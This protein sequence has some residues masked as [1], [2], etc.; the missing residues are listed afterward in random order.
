VNGDVDYFSFTAPANARIWAYVDT[1]GV[2]AGTSVDSLLQLIATDGTTQLELDDSDGT[3]NGL[4][5]TVETESSS[6]IAGLLGPPAGGLIYARISE[7]GDNGTINPM[8][9]YVVT[10]TTSTP[11]VEGAGGNNSCATANQL[12]SG[13]PHVGVRTGEIPAATADED[14][15]SVSANSGDILYLA[16]D[17]DPERNGS[18][19]LELTLISTDGTTVLLAADSDNDSPL[20]EAF[21]FQ[22]GTTGTFCVRVRDEPGGG[23]DT[24]TYAVMVANTSQ[25]VPVE[26]QRFEVD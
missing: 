2:Q 20:S 5:G 17:G 1:G 14:F 15:Y 3:G 6:S 18:T 8:T 22:V 10:T 9:L 16:L 7:D 21:A 4:D 26:L 25:F 13:V 19:D 23:V 24:G 11:E 12:Y